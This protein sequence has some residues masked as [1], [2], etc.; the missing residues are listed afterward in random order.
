MHRSMPYS[1]VLK[2]PQMLI[3]YSALEKCR[4]SQRIML[5]R[6]TD[7]KRV[8]AGVHLRRAWVSNPGQRN[9]LPLS[10]GT[11]FTVTMIKVRG[12][13]KLRAKAKTEGEK[14]VYR[15]ENIKAGLP[16]QG[17]Y[18]LANNAGSR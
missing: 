3:W 13:S 14:K 12:K 17:M 9:S 10:V 4:Q 15:N 5:L 6:N 7:L 18:Q 8:R 1:A 2:D 16:N 11:I